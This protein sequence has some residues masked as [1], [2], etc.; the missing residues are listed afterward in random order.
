MVKS[1][2]SYSVQNLKKEKE[3]A[4]NPVT[5]NPLGVLGLKSRGKLQEY[6]MKSTSII[7][8]LDEDEEVIVQVSICVY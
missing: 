2:H 4:Q 3:M 7:L 8:D 6:G 1:K 5:Q